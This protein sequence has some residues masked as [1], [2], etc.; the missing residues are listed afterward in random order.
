MT[1]VGSV[2]AGDFTIGLGGWQKLVNFDPPFL[3]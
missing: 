1:T 3:G 2:I